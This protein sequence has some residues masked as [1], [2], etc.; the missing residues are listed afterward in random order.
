MPTHP[1]AEV[2]GFP[3]DNFSNEAE[4]F[5]KN[6]LCPFNNKSPN[7]TKSSV[8]NPLGVCSVFGGEDIV[9]TC[10]VRFRQNWTITIDYRTHLSMS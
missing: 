5:R 1:L 10:P 3:T 4:R 9:I 7:C 8:E 2:F 6:H